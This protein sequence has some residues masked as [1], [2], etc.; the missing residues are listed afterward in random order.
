MTVVAPSPT[1]RVAIGALLDGPDDVV[2]LDQSCTETGGSELHVEVVERFVADRIAAAEM[3][4][5]LAGASGVVVLDVHDPV[6][7][8]W[9]ASLSVG[10]V[11][12]LDSDAERLR[13]TLA[14]VRAGLRVEFEP[15]VRAPRWLAALTAANRRWLEHR[16]DRGWTVAQLAASERMSQTA[17]KDQLRALRRTMGIATLDEAARAYR[18]WRGVLAPTI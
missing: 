12:G 1:L 17:M 7:G 14:A 15:P 9:A 6:G 2:F 16:L 5:E 3:R 11:L 18:P 4:L 8:A 10:A 13:A